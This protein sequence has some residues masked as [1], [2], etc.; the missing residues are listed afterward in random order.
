[1]IFLQC[2]SAAAWLCLLSR[3]SAKAIPYGETSDLIG[4]DRDFRTKT[5]IILPLH[6]PNRL[7]EDASL[8]CD[9]GNSTA[10]SACGVSQVTG[11]WKSMN[12]MTVITIG[13]KNYNVVIDTGSGDFFLFGAA[14]RC[15]R[16]KFRH[17][18]AVAQEQCRFGPL[19]SPSISSPGIRGTFQREYMNVEYA[20]GNFERANVTLGGITVNSEIGVTTAATNWRGDTIRSGV[21]GLANPTRTRASNGTWETRAFSIQASPLFA[22]FQQRLAAPFFTLVLPRESSWIPAP[23]LNSTHGGYLAIG[24]LGPAVTPNTPFIRTPIVDKER[25][26]Y[27]RLPNDWDLSTDYNIHVDGFSVAE[28]RLDGRKSWRDIGGSLIMTI[29]SGSSMITLPWNTARKINQLFDPPP[30]DVII[31]S[32]EREHRPTNVDCNA[33]PP[34]ITFSISGEQFHI[35]PPN[36]I[37]RISPYYCISTIGSSWGQNNILGA[38]FLRNAI[39]VFDIGQNEMRF[40]PRP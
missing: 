38:P 6:G 29:D 33:K 17:L 2:L 3:G 19:Y 9:L 16:R 23:I 30:S 4:P 36:L 11:L 28:D 34:H 1:M 37:Q 40:A 32:W 20:S 39:A 8:N 5:P 14:T 27:H 35:P 13:K 15:L 18:Y 24:H 31:P 25:I 21:L 22:M 10:S 7:P 26:D 12:H